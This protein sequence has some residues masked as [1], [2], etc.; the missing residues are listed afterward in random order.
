MTESTKLMCC[1]H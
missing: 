1:I